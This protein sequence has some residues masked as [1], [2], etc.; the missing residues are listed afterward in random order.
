M[1]FLPLTVLGVMGFASLALAGGASGIVG[2]IDA[3]ERT[4]TLETGESFSVAETVALTDLEQIRP[5][6]TVIISYDEEDGENVAST[7]ELQGSSTDQ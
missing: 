7:V 4:L 2:E 3:Q 6:D 1:R 5:G